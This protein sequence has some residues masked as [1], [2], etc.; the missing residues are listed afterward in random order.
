MAVG[1]E[2]AKIDGR[3]VL[4]LCLLSGLFIGVGAG[5]SFTPQQWLSVE[6]AATDTIQERHTNRENY[7]VVTD[8]S[9]ST[10]QS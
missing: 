5:A 8:T 9:V 10:S 1:V 3:K 4:V 2:W 6:E 7:T